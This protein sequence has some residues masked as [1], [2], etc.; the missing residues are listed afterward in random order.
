M[1][2]N[3]IHKTMKKKLLTLI[4]TAVAAIAAFCQPAPVPPLGTNPP[5]IDYS[6]P[7]SPTNPPGPLGSPAL[8]SNAPVVPAAIT[9]GTVFSGPVHWEISPG[10]WKETGLTI[11]AEANNGVPANIVKRTWNSNLVMVV[12][13]D[14]PHSFI[15]KSIPYREQQGVYTSENVKHYQPIGQ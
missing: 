13:L 11:S 2:Q 4:M 14:G 7:P 1:S 15:L 5:P 9:N 6:A 10:E 3:K 8:A 12:I